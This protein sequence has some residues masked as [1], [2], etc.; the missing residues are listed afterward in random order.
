MNSAKVFEVAEEHFL[1]EI[2]QMLEKKAGQGIV[3]LPSLFNFCSYLKDIQLNRFLEKNQSFLVDQCWTQLSLPQ[4]TS[5]LN[6]KK[7]S[8]FTKKQKNLIN[9]ISWQ[10]VVC[11]SFIKFNKRWH[12][13]ICKVKQTLNPCSVHFNY[14]QT[15]ECIFISLNMTN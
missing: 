11:K 5:L 14:T 3:Q 6:K 7:L 4:E 10:C 15:H 8:S 2:L 1:Q 9:T 13:I 12:P